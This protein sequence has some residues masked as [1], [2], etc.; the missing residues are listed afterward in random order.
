MFRQR[1]EGA[2]VR[3]CRRYDIS[4]LFASSCGIKCTNQLLSSDLFK[5]FEGFS[6]D[7]VRTSNLYIGFD[8]LVDSSTLLGERLE[9]AP[10]VG[11]MHHLSQAEDIEHCDYVR[12]VRAGT[13]DFR[14]RQHVGPVQKTALAES[15]RKAR[16]SVESGSY[17][18]IQVCT[19]DGKHY[20]ANGKHRAALCVILGIQPICVDVSLVM[21]DSFYWWVYHKM[22]KRESVFQKHIAWFDRAKETIR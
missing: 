12:R 1:V 14:P 21:F 6:V 8:A 13:L 18:P 11:L 17:D 16:E 19:I 15:F 5:F 3:L 2:V 10:H 4:K 22:K 9:D 7:E 20:I